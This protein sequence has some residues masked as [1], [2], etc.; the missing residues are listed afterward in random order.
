VRERPRSDR[1][2]VRPKTNCRNTMGVQQHFDSKANRYYEHYYR[3]GRLNCYVHNQQ[4][5]RQYFR[6]VILANGTP[7]G[8][9]ALDVGSGPGSIALDLLER[10]WETFCVDVSFKMLL[11]NRKNT[12]SATKLTQCSADALSYKD[13]TFDIVTAAGVLEY[14]RDDS[15]ALREIVR[16]LKPGGTLI[17]S[18]PIGKAMSSYIRMYLARLLFKRETN[19]FCRK[20]YT[21]KNFRK[22]VEEVGFT[23]RTSISHHFVFFPVDYLFPNISVQLDY[24]LTSILGKTS[25]LGSLGKTLII[26]AIKPVKAK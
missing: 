23:V 22:D 13:D 17:I 8:G 7:G 15:K 16:V 19:P 4:M 25:L 6:N 10:G 12:R 24:F 11:H 21:V 1:H 9:M 26:S 3:S 18:V 5:R 20:G 2:L 14:V